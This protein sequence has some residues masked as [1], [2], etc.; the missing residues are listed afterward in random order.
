MIRKVNHLKILSSGIDD[1]GDPFVKL[2]NG[3]IF[4]GDNLKSNLDRY[5]YK[6]LSTKT[7]QNLQSESLQVAVDIVI[8][9][10]E[11]GLKYGGPKKQSRYNVRPGDSV[12]E[13]G[14]YQ[15]FC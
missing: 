10:V 9:Y 11:G 1:E 13:M 2:E 15:G 7:K 3:T 4:F 14:G 8:R 5:L 6:L 12:S